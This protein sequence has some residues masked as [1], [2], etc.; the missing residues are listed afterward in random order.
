MGFLFPT[1]F[2]ISVQGHAVPCKRMLL[3]HFSSYCIM[4]L[5]LLLRLIQ[6]PV[7][8]SIILFKAASFLCHIDSCTAAE[9]CIRFL[10]LAQMAVQPLHD[11]ANRSIRIFHVFYKYNEFITSQTV[12]DIFFPESLTQSPAKYLQHPVPQQMSTGIVDLF[13]IINIHQE[14]GMISFWFFTLIFQKFLYVLP[15]CTSIQHS[16]QRVDLCLFL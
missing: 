14:H 1:D 8:L 5:S 2:S 10:H 11:R 13:E 9:I 4:T 7:C 12:D 6:C 3:F 15:P 16:G